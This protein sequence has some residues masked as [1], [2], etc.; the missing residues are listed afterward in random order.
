MGEEWNS[1]AGFSLAGR[2]RDVLPGNE[3]RIQRYLL[4]MIEE[5]RKMTPEIMA[6][7]NESRAQVRNWCAEQFERFDL[8]ITPTTPY[9]AVPARGPFPSVTDGKPQDPFAAGSF[10]QP[11]NLAWQPAASVRVGLSR[12]DMPIGMQIVGPH[13]RDDLVLQASLAFERERP[14]NDVWPASVQK[15]ESR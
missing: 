4:G 3:E 5:G 6:R 9:D 12:H 15:A 1:L 7:I 11:F 8:L 13:H 2:L 10:T 14:W